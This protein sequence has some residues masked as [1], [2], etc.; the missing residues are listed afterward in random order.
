MTDSGTLCATIF[1]VAPYP[2]GVVMRQGLVWA[3]LIG[4]AVAGILSEVMLFRMLSPPDAEAAFLAGAWI[5]MPFL[6]T[7]GMMMLIR[8][9][10]AA[11]IVML[12]ALVLASFVGVS[13]LNSAVEARIESQKQVRE[14]V[15]PG[16]DPNSGPAGM[17]KTGADVGA[18]ISDVFSV[19][20]VVFIPPLQLVA[21][22]IPTL[23]GYGVSA[24]VRRRQEPEPTEM[25]G[26][27]LA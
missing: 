17:R 16:E 5:A 7:M 15:G 19:A 27:M 4:S 1:P 11:L 8:R 6:G 24:L 10:N 23:I 22:V 12:V 3:I 25:V 26:T 21:V 13:I 20:V 9:N 14:A 2:W 18:T